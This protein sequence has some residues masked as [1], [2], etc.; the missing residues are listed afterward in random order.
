MV[1]GSELLGQGNKLSI[2]VTPPKNISICG[3]NDTALVQAYN[4]SVSTITG[5]KVTLNL[6]PGT[7]YIKSSVKGTGLSENNISN[8]NQPVFNAPNLAVA[9]NFIFR[10]S[11][12]AGCG[13]Y[14]YISGN[15]SPVI[16]SRIDYAGNYDVGT[17]LPFSAKVPS[18]LISTITNQTFTGNVNDVF[19]RSITIGNYG[20]G[21][22]RS[23]TLKRING[24]DLKTYGVNKG[25]NTFKGDT[26]ITVFGTSDFKKVGNLD[27]FLDQNE[28]IIVTDTSRIIACK[29]L[30]TNYELSW[31]CFGSICQLVKNSGIALISSQSPNLVAFPTAS[32]PVCFNNKNNNQLLKITNNGQKPAFNTRASIDQGYFYEMSKL[33]TNSVLIKTGWKGT[34]IKPVFDSTSY[35]YAI[36]SYSCLGV[37][38]IGAFRIKLGTIYPKDTV[39][40]SFK[41][42]TCLPALCNS[43]YYTNSWLFGTEYYDQCNNKQT[44]PM[45]WAKY[46]DYTSVTSSAFTPTDIVDKQKGEFRH[47]FTAFNTLNYDATAA[48]EIN[49]IVPKGLSHSLNKNDFFLND[50][51]LT[52]TWKPDSIRQKGDTVRAYF[53]KRPFNLINSELIYY[54]TADC[55]VA[56]ANGNQLV[57]LFIRYITSKS[58][59]PLE[60]INLYCY[61]MAIKIHCVSTCAQGLQFVDFN[62]QRTSYGAPDNDNN[63]LPDATGTIDLLKIRE[64]RAM[65]GDTITATYIGKVLKPKGIAVGWDYLYVESFI[66]YGNF[67]DVAGADLVVYRGG[68]KKLFSCNSIKNKKTTSGANATFKFYLSVDSLSA[69]VS[70]AFNYKKS[71]SVRLFVYYKLTNNIGLTSYTTQFNNSFYTSDISNPTQTKNKFQCDTF[72]GQIILTGYQYLNYGPDNYSVNSCGN[73]DISQSF[74]LGIGANSAYAGNNYF[75]FEYRSFARLKEI[76]IDLPPGF[77]LIKTLLG[78]YRTSG[79]NQYV[80]Q[81]KDS[82]KAVYKNGKY[83]FETSKYYKDSANGKFELSDDAFQ[84]YF[85]ATIQPSCELPPG[86]KIPIKYD[87]VFEKKGSLKGGYD[88]INSAYY[89]H[90]QITFNKPVFSVKPAIPVNYASKDTAE[91]DIIYTNSSTSF[92]TVNCWFSPDNTG[93]IKVVD[94][95][96][97]VADTS[98]KKVNDIYKAG[99]VPFNV[100]RRFKVKAIYNSC[101]KDSVIL[102]SGWNCIDYPKDFAS[103]TCSPEKTVLYLEPQNTQFQVSLSDSI[104]TAD[105][106]AQSPYYYLLENIGATNAYNTK[107][108][109]TLPVG[110]LVVSGKS[111]I[112]HPLKSSWLKLPLPQ[113]V[114][115]TTYEWDLSKLQS[116]LAQGYRGITDTTRNKILIKFY[117]KTDCDYSSGNYI[118]ASAVANIKCGDKVLVFPAI[119]NPLNITGVTKPYYSLLKVNADTI[120]PCEKSSKVKIKIINLGPSKTGIEDKYQAILPSGLIYDSTLFKATNNAPDNSLTKTRDINGATEVEFSLPSGIFPGDS[121][122]FE[123]GFS[124]DN[125][126]IACG[127]TDLYSQA[128]V[129]QE[130]ICVADNSKCKINVVTGNMLLKIP[131]VKG[132]L[133][134]SKLK[135]NIQSI[136]ADSETLNISFVIANPGQN[137]ISSKTTKLVFYYDKNNSGTIDNNDLAIKTINLNSKFNKGSSTIINTSITI[138]AGYSCALFMAIDSSSCSC[139]FGQYRLPV[140]PLVNAGADIS[141]CSRDKN[142]LGLTK[143]NGFSYA[144]QPS[145]DLNNDTLAQPSIIYENTGNKKETRKYI[146]TTKRLTCITR[147]TVLATIYQLPKIKLRQG[148]TIICK[149]QKVTLKSSASNGTGIIKSLWYPSKQVS[150]STKPQTISTTVKT[151]RYIIKISDS[152]N[153]KASDSM[154]ITTKPY[155][156][157]NF[158]FNTGCYGTAVLLTDSSYITQDSIK[159][160]RWINGSFD[161]LNSKTWQVNVPSTLKTNVSLISESPYKCKDTITKTVIVKPIPKADFTFKNICQYD[162]ANFTNTSTVITG[163]ITQYIWRFGDNST[164]SKQHTRHHYLTADTFNTSLKITSDSKCT[165]SIAKKIIVNHLPTAGFN[166]KN[167]CFGDSSRFTNTSTITKDSI[168]DYLWYL[169]NNQNSAAINPTYFYNKD[170]IWTISLET[171]TAFGCKDFITKNTTVY[172]LPKARILTDTVC[173]GNMNFF[174]EKSTIAK[175]ALASRNWKLSDGYTSANVNFSRRFSK[176]DTFSLHYTVLS[177]KGCKDSTDGYAMVH[178]RL[179]PLIQLNNNCLGAITYFNDLSSGINTKAKSWKWILSN[180]DSSVFQNPKFIYPT[181]GTTKVILKVTSTEGCTYDTFANQVTYPLPVLAIANTNKCKDNQFDFQSNNSIL[182]GTIDSLLW[183][184]DDGSFANTTIVKHVFP[185]AGAYNVKLTGI[186]DFGCVDSTMQIINSYPP[187]V[188]QF[189]NDSLCLGIPTQ[190]T[191]ECKVP[192][193]TITDYNWDFGDGQRDNIGNP[194][195]L[196]AQYG[197]YKVNL[198]ITTSYNCV[199]DTVGYARIYPVPVSKFSTNPNEVLITNPVIEFTDLSTGADSMIYNMG[200]GKYKSG[201]VFKY[202]Y[203]DSGVFKVQQWTYNNFGCIDSSSKDIVVHFTLTFYLPNAFSPNDDFLNETLKPDGI[204]IA[205]FEMAIYNRWGELIYNTMDSQPWDGKYEGEYVPTGCY[206]VVYKVHDYKGKI[207]VYKNIVTVLR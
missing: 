143:V 192:N 17:S 123:M 137:I 103:Y 184:F 13:L 98:L 41:N 110:M 185:K 145:N 126:L 198:E 149:G 116:S 66:Y 57:Q 52:A 53:S 115:G 170:T 133:T 92:S 14:S 77:K 120:F 101:K 187:V 44:I 30:T 26:I 85:Y 109:L 93:S 79:S 34:W 205:K 97:A 117:V 182:S 176:G 160:N 25:S 206:T 204:G 200:D 203:P 141:Y 104:T 146:L 99:V 7:F 64:E 73:M 105:L 113:L 40:I 191:D 207:F 121:M 9:S 91:W 84:G 196:Y 135:T 154:L 32:T 46:Y 75:P 47:L 76:I 82:I 90:D 1:I 23:L 100:T 78:Q 51:N 80:L 19:T 58:C 2:Q 95:R 193:A 55:S 164:D 173:E 118:R 139:S 202:N 68:T 6:P 127:A 128:A 124:A 20:K 144:W 4:I 74:Y 49:I 71:D 158:T 27:T 148:D 21:P 83:T 175:G 122:E 12:T 96:D 56:G 142:T 167:V 151:T 163:I 43:F 59:N 159:F 5:I 94:I 63:G 131:V 29:F 162:T 42:Y 65:V 186:S 48:Y 37:N 10:V 15:N 201:K 89:G 54:L 194:L 195:H 45:A 138:K 130:V 140:P 150:D 152:F 183:N 28:T 157:S 171:K 166:V 102:Y 67:M 61:N 31:G 119:S 112:K 18:I 155:P 106:C 136:T 189:S 132:D 188:V 8:L 72:S 172:P 11:I 168:T 33:D 36:G 129:K 86:V 177:D 161:T 70:S 178:P 174:I 87:F 50:A 69:C 169:D 108:Q 197:L 147:D 111:Y 24:K 180:K 125:K 81:T 3:I 165:D 38:P 60:W 107:A 179:K 39:Y 22:L 16:I 114:S 156:K 35:T 134:I 199:Y 181:P 88:T 153:C 190:F 62:V